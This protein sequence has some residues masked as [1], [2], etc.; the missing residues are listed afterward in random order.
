MDVHVSSPIIDRTG[1]LH[2]VVPVLNIGNGI[3]QM[4][5]QTLSELRLAVGEKIA[6]WALISTYT[7]LS[8]SRGNWADKPVTTG[9]NM[10]DQV[11]GDWTL[12]NYTGY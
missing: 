7:P 5:D 2:G 12:F 3:Q 4:R 6:C 8:E 1:I 9:P 10:L 11:R